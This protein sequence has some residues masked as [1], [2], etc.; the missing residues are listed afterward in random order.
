M[1]RIVLSLVLFMAVLQMGLG[2]TQVKLDKNTFG[3]LKARSIGPAVMSGRVA[4]LDAVNADPRILY[5]GAAG[6]G[7]WKTTNGGTTFK[8]VFEKEIQAIGAIAIDQ[9]HPDTVWVGTGE[10]WTRNSTSVGNGIYRT[11]NGGDDWNHMGLDSTERIARIMVDPK[12]PSTVYVAALGPLWSASPHRGLFKTTD[13]GET[14]QKILY[15]DDN[16]GCSGLAIDPANP[17]LIYAG[18]WDFRRTGWSFRSGGPGSSFFRSEDGGKT[19]TSIE[20]NLTPKPWG[21]VYVD[22]SPADPNVVYL[23]IEAKKTAFY[24]SADKGKN[25]EMVNNSNDVNER[26][27]YFGFFVPDPVDTNRIYKPGFSLQM[28]EDGGKKFMSPAVMG[29]NFHSDVHGIWISPKNNQLIYLATDGGVYISVDQ[30]KTWSFCRNLPISQFYHVSVDNEKPY[31]VFGGLQDNGSWIGPSKA[32]GGVS[33]ANWKNIGWGDGFNVLRDPIDNNIMYWQWQG[34]NLR[35]LY[36]DT[37]ENKDVMP[38]SK[39]TTKLR[40]NWNTPLVFGAASGDLYTGSQFLFRSSDHGDS[41]QKISPDLTTNDPKKLN[42]EQTGGLTIDNSTAENHCTIFTIGESPLDDKIIW[43]GTD[44]GNLQLTRNGG[45]TWENLTYSVP[46]L[47]PT[48]WCSHVEPS[49]YDKATAFVTFDGHWQGDM[50]P[51][52]YKTTDFGKTWKNLFSPDI[53]GYCNT[54]RQDLKN[55]DLLFL[56]TESGLYIS[57][58]GGN[59]WTRFTGNLPKVSVREMAFQPRENDLVIATHGRGIYILDDLTPIQNLKTDMLNQNLV[60]LGSRPYQLGYMGG[61]QEF[62]GDDDFA[63]DNPP[64]SV[65]INYYMK[66][67]HVFGD[68]FME[69]Y[70][71][72][73]EMIKKLPAGKR[74]GINRVQW[75]MQMKRPKVPSSVQLLGWAMLGPSYPPGEYTVRIIKNKDTITG[76][77]KVQYDDN[78]HHTIADRDERYKYLMKAYH[79]LEDLAY[80]DNQ[81]IELR[82]QSAAKSDSVK[83]NLIKKLSTLSEN[84]AALRLKIVATRE[85]RIT[86]EERLRER[87]GNI[88]GGLLGYQGRP[89]Q[90][91]ITGLKELGDQMKGYQ[92]QVDEIISNTL[93]V[94]NKK[95]EKSGLKPITLTDKKTFLE[96]ESS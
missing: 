36:L 74:K 21:R 48:T 93:P 76:P 32:A 29:G 20:K 2:Q 55:P 66:K 85:G 18:M 44:D 37:R 12:N 53:E 82:D 8:P 11:T 43:A 52:V 47:P 33:N 16:T 58:D 86:G 79:M 35:R 15:V 54:V 81:I 67:R 91:Q 1:K 7:I 10:P 31:N 94:Y 46:G 60:Y 34:G 6:G 90:S 9:S 71:Q 28:S 5:V 3:E 89:T 40:W 45:Q 42:Q 64:S 30:A 23:L 17:D 77:I 73:G 75:R 50:R 69:V 65:S 39:D 88:Y 51:Y 41:W 38:Y 24:R 87:I 25:W 72:D 68:M 27:F 61:I 80:L 14:W 63:G 13:G 83:G 78:P 49:P 59:Q 62:N 26:P 4:A 92:N 56:G 57:I 96:K 84:M 95:L 22:F 70:D 19:W